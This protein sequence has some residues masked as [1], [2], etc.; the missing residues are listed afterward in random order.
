MARLEDLTRGTHVA[1]IRPDGPVEVLDVKW[2]GTSALELTFKG[3][4]GK[5]GNEILFRDREASLEI[6]SRGPSRMITREIR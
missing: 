4:D 1:G 6:Q 5:P 3:S 2:H